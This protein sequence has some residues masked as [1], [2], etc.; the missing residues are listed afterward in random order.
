MLRELLE[1][2]LKRPLPGVEYQMKMSPENR[3]D[4]NVT[5]DERNAAVAVVMVRTKDTHEFLL[6]K[7]PEYDGVHSA[8][9][10]FPG[11]KAES[12]DS[13][14]LYTAIRETR[15]EIGM[16]LSQKECI[17]SLTSLPIPVSRFVVQPYV[18]Y[19][20]RMPELS[21]DPR[22]VQYMIRAP[23]DILL[24]PDAMKQTSLNIRGF[25]IHTP[26]FS[27]G[28]EIVWGATGMML[29]EFAEV[30]RRLEMKNP[31]IL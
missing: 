17:G 28:N 26:Y 16:L 13:S 11:G 25:I 31:G 29:A 2:E 27:I 14:L 30:L 18:F 19:L 10:S 15:E 24:D 3:P 6:I 20:D 9:V 22:E 5:G 4:F 21:I 23:L 7:R 8:Q 1:I 12:E